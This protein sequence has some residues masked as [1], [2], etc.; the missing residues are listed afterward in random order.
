MLARAEGVG[1]PR[2][3]AR[4]RP[5]VATAS[6][7]PACS[8]RPASSRARRRSGRRCRSVTRSRRRSSSRRASRCSTPGSRSA[9][10]TSVRPGC[11][12][13]RRRRRPRPARAWTSTSARVAEREPGMNPIEVLTSE[14]QE[15]MLAIV[16]PGDLDEVLAL[17]ERWEIRATVVGRVTDSGRFRVFDGY[18]DAIGVPGANPTPPLGDE[19]PEVS[20]DRHPGRRRPDREPRRR[21]AL[22]PAARAAGRPRRAPGRRSRRP[23]C[24]RASRRARTSSAELLDL[25][26]S[27]NIADKSWVWR[28]YDHQLFLNTVVGPGGD[29]AV[30]RLKE[31]DG[32]AL[33]LSVD[34]KGRFCRAR[35]A[36]RC[37][38]RGARGRA[39]RRVQRRPP[40]RARELPELRQ[41]RAPRG[42]VAVLRGGRRHGRGLPRARHPGRR[43]QREL[44]QRVARRATSTRRRSSA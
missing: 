1:Q 43:R 4:V 19:P 27:P 25:L 8:R 20:S 5:P 35:P 32:R 44:L 12:A 23:R 24:S 34:G 28:Q 41:P 31:T 14:S 9:C 39:Q 2:G 40:A 21:A 42:D 38:A 17:C 7:A 15:R 13:R 26:A 18:F 37:A 11:R 6:A 29:A 10:R 30:L 22:R 3:A 33:A 36:R 16:T